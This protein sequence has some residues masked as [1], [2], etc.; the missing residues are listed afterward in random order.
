MGA[1]ENRIDIENKQAWKGVGGG[2]IQSLEEWLGILSA[3]KR[4]CGRCETN[5]YIPLP[6][7]EEYIH[8]GRLRYEIIPGRALWLFE[9]ERDYYLGYYYVPKEEK[10]CIRPQNLDVVV[11]LIGSEKKYAAKRE[12]ELA[13]LGF[14]RYRRNLEYMVASEKIPELEK[15]DR[16]C[17]RFM[18]KMNFCYTPFRIEDYEEVFKMW[19]ERIDRYSVK[20]MLKSRIRRAEEKAECLLIRDKEGHI[21]AA[22]AFEV[23]GAAGFSENIATAISCSGTGTGGALLCRSLMN[24]FSRGCTKDSM[25]VWEGNMESR[26]MTE[27]FAELTGRFSQ[28]M[29]LSKQ[30]DIERGFRV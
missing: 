13:G 20:D 11:Y 12:E 17:R 29:L 2:K 9:Q 27:R 28:Q 22:C 1:E 18:E 16:K 24:I 7:M 23:N 14:I 25:W 10:L 4:S 26:R 19:R 21:T 15:M 3:F 6:Q 30:A 5:C 8:E